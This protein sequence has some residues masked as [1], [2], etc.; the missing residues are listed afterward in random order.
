[1]PEYEI[2]LGGATGPTGPLGPT[3]PAGGAT[4]P[5]G[6]A[7]S[8]GLPGPTGVTGA[9]GPIGATGP[10]DPGPTG[11]QGPTGATGPA[12]IAGAVGG[13]GPVGTTGPT[14]P[15]PAKTAGVLTDYGDVSG[16]GSPNLTFNASDHYRARLIGDWTPGSINNFGAPTVVTF[17]VIQDGV[18][19]RIINWPAGISWGLAG[20][21]TL[22]TTLNKADLITFYIRDTAT[23][24]YLGVHSVKDYTPT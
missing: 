11:V 7:G 19:S 13:T 24:Q 14:G 17:E 6:P 10:L 20:P 22:T 12:G 16:V 3:G 21:P 4:G 15:T 23:P 2:P 9:T 8:A 5:T 18:G 1:M